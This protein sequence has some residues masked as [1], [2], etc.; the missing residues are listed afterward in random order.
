[1]GH[2]VPI[3]PP[4]VLVSNNVNQGNQVN[5]N[6]STSSASSSNSNS[7]SSQ[8][9]SN[10]NNY[11]NQM[12]PTNNMV[13][14]PPLSNP[15][16]YSWNGSS[17]GVSSSVTNQSNTSSSSNGLNS[18]PSQSSS[19]GAPQQ[20]QQQQQQQQIQYS[21]QYNQQYQQPQQQHQQNG[22][23][24][25]PP[26]FRLVLDSTLPVTN[27]SPPLANSNGTTSPPG[28][29]NFTTPKSTSSLTGFKSFDFQSPLSTRNNSMDLIAN[30]LAGGSHSY[31]SQQLPT[32]PQYDSNSNL[33]CSTQCIPSLSSIKSA[34]APHIHSHH[35]SHTH[36]KRQSRTSNAGSS[37]SSTSSH[38]PRK[39]RE[40]PICHNFFSNLTTHK[41]I[42]NKDSKP[43]TCSTCQR[44][45]KRM[46]DLLRHEKCHLSKLGEWEFQCPYHDPTGGNNNSPMG[47]EDVRTESCHHTGYFTRCD[48]YKNHL[49]A[50]HFKYPQNTLK[51]DRFKVS[52]HCK[53][54]GMYFD[55]VQDWLI[56]HVETYQCP[57]MINTGKKR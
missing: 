26:L 57:K 44:A 51:S 8:T 43:F 39:K 23:S 31:L 13:M 37:S 12:L 53:E 45:F 16:N 1:M 15:Y 49:K 42:H 50:I 30:P 47:S 17:M 25:L 40:C 9:N 27:Y 36:K 18:I 46:N 21:Q 48:T 2:Q 54:C 20:Q 34:T 38:P 29:S 7:N 32:P 52:G 55:N 24:N 10:P 28:S 14:L 22:S 19:M 4:P 3:L 33:S 6:S 35:S 5:H 11:L 56:N 41:S